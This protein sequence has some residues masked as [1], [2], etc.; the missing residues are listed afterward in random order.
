MSRKAYVTLLTAPAYLPGVLVLQACL[1]AVGAQHPLVV[2]ATP[3]LSQ[4]VR[5]ILQARGI[6]IR[7]VD[8]LQPEE[9]THKLDDHDAR[10][11]DTWTKLRYV[12]P[13]RVFPACAG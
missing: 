9:G 13:R 2:M 11:R 7:D 6:V 4:E 8:H 3:S 12:W 10:F 1:V 5:S